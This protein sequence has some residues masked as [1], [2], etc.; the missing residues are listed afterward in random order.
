MN[1]QANSRQLQSR[2]AENCASHWA[3]LLVGSAR[4]GIVRSLQVI[5]ILGIGLMV[6]GRPASAQ[7]APYKYQII[8]IPGTLMSQPSTAAIRV[9]ANE[10]EFT[11]FFYQFDRLISVS[12]TIDHDIYKTNPSPVPMGG[13][14]GGDARVNSIAKLLTSNWLPDDVQA[15]DTYSVTFKSNYDKHPDSTVSLGSGDLILGPYLQRYGYDFTGYFY[16]REGTRPVRQDA[17]VRKNV[18]VYAGWQPWDAETLKNESLYKELMDRGQYIM[19]RP[20]AYEEKS[21]DRFYELAFL[22]YLRFGAG[23]AKVTDANVNIV[24]SALSAMK[25]VKQIRDPNKSAWYIWGAQMAEE[26]E[27]DKFDF[28]GYLDGPHW[29][30]FLVPYMLTDQS[31]VKGNIVVV[32]GGGYLLRSNIEEAYSTAEVFN[33]L[34]Y[35]TFVLQRRVSPYAPVDSFLDV[36]R[37]VRY[38]NFHAKEYGVAK[39][40]NLATC[41]F[42][43]GGGTITGAAEHYFG[44]VLPSSLYK[45]Y[46]DDE[47]DQLNSDSKALLVIYSSGDVLHSQNP[48]YP[49]TFIAFGSND[50]L[51]RGAMDFYKSLLSK[52]PFVEIHGFTS[53]PHGFGAGTGVPDYTGMSPAGFGASTNQNA[54]DYKGANKPY[55][56][57]YTGAQQWTR[58]ADTFLDQV[59]GYKPVSY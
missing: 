34:G 27:A 42:S 48:Q 55:L 51:S 13:P 30:P 22:A 38:L 36:Q 46:K 44:H 47:I 8:E 17:V 3:G 43:G 31:R 29:R 41:G 49:A 37:A 58:L 40:E 54:T 4:T 45:D 23:G 52:T 12:G 39:I 1:Y 53:T 16:D 59:F 19:E 2:H 28:F 26:P 5:G 57:A 25:D 50:F 10:T 32:A 33:H 11:A 20:T 21:F 7:T 56:L 35:N 14:M 18:T 9:N 6:N 15:G 24:T